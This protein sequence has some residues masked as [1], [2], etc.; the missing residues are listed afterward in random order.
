[1]SRRHVLN[2]T[3]TVI[4]GTLGRPSLK[5]AIESFLAQDYAN[6]RTYGGSPVIFEF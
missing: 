3:V 2:P 1:M 6:A 5:K 4:C